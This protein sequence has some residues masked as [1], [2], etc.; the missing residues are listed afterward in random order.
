MQRKC[1]VCGAVTDTLD[2]TC[3]SAC[4][5][6]L[7]SDPED[8]IGKAIK[9]N[10]LLYSDGLQH[11]VVKVNRI[12]P[13]FVGR[14]ELRWTLFVACREHGSYSIDHVRDA[15]YIRHGKVPS[16]LECLATPTRV[17]SRK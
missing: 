15:S 17:Y 4:L 10:L 1:Y 11:T 3:S 14:P 9:F 6:D 13:L 12:R 5:L 8:S 7:V 2:E 16:C